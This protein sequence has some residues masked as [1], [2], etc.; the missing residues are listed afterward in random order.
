MLLCPDSKPDAAYIGVAANLHG[1]L[2]SPDVCMEVQ[3]YSSSNIAV[4]PTLSSRAAHE[5]QIQFELADS[6]QLGPN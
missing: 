4:H 1:S 2:H 5:H 3:H 6:S